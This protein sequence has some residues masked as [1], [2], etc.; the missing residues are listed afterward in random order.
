MKSTNKQVK[1]KG[2]CSRNKA[3]V[4]TDYPFYRFTAWR[5]GLRL[6]QKAV[7]QLRQ[8]RDNFGETVFAVQEQLAQIDE[9]ARN[10]KW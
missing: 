3:G 2:I 6:V 9:F 1:G 8:K 7:S 10:G 5:E 4:L